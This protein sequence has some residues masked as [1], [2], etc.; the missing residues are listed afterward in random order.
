M[1]STLSLA[2]LLFT[3]FLASRAT[4]GELQ[5]VGRWKGFPDWVTSVAFS[6]DGQLLAAGSYD[7]VKL[8]DMTTSQEVATFKAGTGF[9]KSLAYSPSGNLLAVG[10]YQAVDVWDVKTQQ[11]LL[12]LKG[13][14]GYVTG[15]AFQEDYLI[16]GGEDGHIRIWNWKT[17]NFSTTLGPVDQPVQGIALHPNGQTLAIACGDETRLSRKGLVAVMSLADGSLLKQFSDHER[18]ATCVNWTN[19]D[20]HWLL[21]GSFDE[22]VNVTD[23]EQPKA[24]GFYGGH[25][26]PV[27]AVQLVPG[28]QWAASVSG[29]RFKG[30]NELNVW[31]IADGTTIASIEAHEQPLTSVTVSSQKMIA[32]GSRDKSV[33]IWS[34]EALT[35]APATESSQTNFQRTSAGLVYFQGDVKPLRIGVIGLD[36]SHSIAFTKT[37]NT[38]PPRPELAGMR[39]VAAYPY[40]SRD[41]ESSVSRIPDYTKQVEDLGVKVV[42]SIPALLEQVDCVLL[43][44]NDGRPHLEQLRPVIEA[45][46]PVFVDKPIAGS[47]KDCLAMFELAKQHNVPMFSSSSLRFMEGAQAA[48]AGEWGTVTGCDAFSPC[49]LEVTHPD[50]FWYGIHGV[51][52]LFTVMGPDVET[53]SRTSQAGT[54]FVV[55]TWK[56]D[57]VGT[58]RG[59][60][61]GKGGY[62]GTVFSDQG[63]KQLEGFKGYDPLVMKIGHFFRTG[64]TPVS[65]E[66]TIAIYAFMEAADESK[67]QGGVPV[68]IAE[69]L[70][71]AR[72]ELSR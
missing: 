22:H 48:R 71:K 30:K 56:G 43:E 8:R 36:T 61:S 28:T 60:R 52:I 2:L 12:R 26:R 25:S 1:K 69:T 68:S 32:V 14:K 33:S 6:P 34:M 23:V 62:G 27:N 17:G 65:A 7:I 31:E 18:P 64:E 42:D 45:G 29:G 24:R 15:V 57:R 19:D 47:L 39:V 20:N 37:F 66:E 63:T 4:A 50:L 59:I 38:D 46:K 16:A 51:E 72:A 44:T 3:P 54:D 58:F 21:S 55:G 70:A 9:V 53:V 41:I 5:E 11:R 10:A 49:S 40:G 13:A 67:R 35:S